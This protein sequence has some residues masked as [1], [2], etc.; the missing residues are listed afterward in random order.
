MDAGWLEDFLVLAETL[1]FSRAA[2]RRNVTQSAMS[3]RI[4][5]LEDWIGASLFSRDTH[6]LDLTPAGER[7]RDTAAEVTR[8]LVLGRE[9]AREAADRAALPLRFASTH[10]LSILFFP[11]W[12]Q[13]MEERRPLGPVRLTADTMAACERLIEQGEAQFLLCHRH[14]AVPDRLA[15]SGFR[16][17]SLGIDTLMPVSAPGRNGSPCHPLPPAPDADGASAGRPA[18]SFRF[19]A[20]DERSGLGRILGGVHGL[21]G[22][23]AGIAPVF[24]SHLATVLHV[25]ALGGRGAAFLPR[26]LVEPDLAAGRLVRAADTR[27]DVSVEICLFRPRARQNAAAEAFWSSLEHAEAP[28]G[29]IFATDPSGPECP[30]THIVAAG[31]P[32][33]DSAPVG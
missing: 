18:A 22:R 10:A 9:A 17:R 21:D 7:F 19:L 2:E 28:C 31:G 15:E 3:R 29:D 8:Q 6:R 4:Q 33:E 12:L 24:T 13:R 32:P 23:S 20:Y 16:H 25:M 14:P 26:S 30:A 5:A 27:W 1:N 11:R